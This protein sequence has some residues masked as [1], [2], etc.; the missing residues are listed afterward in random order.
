MT[1]INVPLTAATGMHVSRP[2]AAT[3]KVAIVGPGHVGVTLAYAC[4][5]RGTGRTIAL[6]GRN[7]EKVRAEV[8]DL[9]HG[10]QFVPM[11]TVTGSDDVEVC[12][13]ADVLVL[14]AGVPYR[15]GQR[16]MDLAADGLAI[17]RDLLPRLLEVA[18]GAVLVI[19]TNPVD[20]VTYAALKISGLPRQRVFGTG[21]MLDS[22][23]L[24]ALIAQRC[25]VAV[26][27]V[28]AYTA[29]EHGES[30]V[31]L[32]TSATV[33]GVPLLRWEDEHPPI[34]VAE[35]DDLRRQVVQA[36]YEV[37]RGKGYTN[38]AIA[39]AT[40]RIIE[41]VLYDEHQVVPVSSLLTGYA[42]ISDV[43]LSVPTVVGRA[44]VVRALPGPLSEDERDGLQH[45]AS[46]IRAVLDK[47]GL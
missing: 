2:A 27:N 21:T 38:H 26:Q 1:T 23:R 44:G 28:H 18:P 4:L 41:A 30:Q 14:T 15:P 6:Y 31:P 32:W 12:R 33:G 9:A 8:A 20:V 10:L 36:G 16:R 19:V 29:G 34:T 37:I 5:I 13:D 39:L 22:S 35:K 3:G 17:Y 40:A 42:G 46:T 43:C 11:A 47:L 7:A 25:G 45:S 24:R